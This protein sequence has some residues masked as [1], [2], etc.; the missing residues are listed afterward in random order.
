MTRPPSGEGDV[1]DE[2]RHRQRQRRNRKD[3]RRDQPGTRGRHRR[4]HGGLS[5][6]RCR[7]AERAPVPQAHDRSGSS[8]STSCFRWWTWIAARS[9]A[10]AARCAA[11]ARL[12]ASAS[13]CSS[14]PNCATPAEA[15]VLACPADALREVPKPIGELRLGMAGPVRFIEGRLNVGEAMS[16]PAIRAVKA[17]SVRGGPADPRLSA[18]HILSGDR[19][20]SR[21]RFG[22]A[23]H[24][25]D[26]LWAPRSEIGGRDGPGLEAAIGRRA[27]PLRHWRRSGPSILHGPA[28]PDSRR[29]RR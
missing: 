28:N 23:G 7:G 27:Q 15:V 17:A 20:R 19:E 10:V 21:Q 11:T 18:G 16:P 4:P 13:K 9:A 12:P 26:A 24:G 14:S 29:D 2:D 25:A 8:R 22:V 5:R 6:L 1:L 3:H